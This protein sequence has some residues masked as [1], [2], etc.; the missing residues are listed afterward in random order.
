MYD[1]ETKRILIE[2]AKNN[3]GVIKPCVGK[4]DF[5]ECFTTYKN[6]TFFWYNDSEGT[7]R[8]EKEITV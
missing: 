7:T 5:N 2:R 8:V 6:S 3:C 1:E 4:K